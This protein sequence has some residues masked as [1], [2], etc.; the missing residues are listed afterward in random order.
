MRTRAISG[1]VAPGA[2][3]LDLV[4]HTAHTPV[5]NFDISAVNDDGVGL[6]GRGQTANGETPFSTG[7]LDRT[8]GKM[9]VFWLDSIEEGKR[10][11]GESFRYTMWADL[12]CTA[13]LF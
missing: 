6:S 9:N 5:G 1:T 3:V 10:Q 12:T 4:S 13:G 2:T 8:T 11:K 7:F